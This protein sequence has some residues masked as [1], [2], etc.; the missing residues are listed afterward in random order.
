MVN[1][2]ENSGIVLSQPSTYILLF[3]QPSFFQA[4]FNF[5]LLLPF[6]VYLH[7]FFQVKRYW[8][9][10]LGFTFLSNAILRSNLGNWHLWDYN[11]AYR[12]FDLDDLLL[13]TT[14]G[15]LSFFIDPA[16]L[17]LFPS[18]QKVNEKAD[19]LLAHDEVKMMSVLLALII[20]LF[21]SKTISNTIFLS[22]P[23]FYHLVP[24]VLFYIND[25][26]IHSYFV[27][28]IK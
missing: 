14:G 20:D 19:E 15:V 17:S 5:L 12:I 10:A 16:V 28:P 11:C 27:S 1:T 4:L 8:K 3:K 7:Y 21:I 6:G 9:K 22:Y 2:F 25:G 13:N 18:K 23:Y 24:G 26:V